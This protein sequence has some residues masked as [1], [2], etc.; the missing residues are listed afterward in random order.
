[1]KFPCLA[2]LLLLAAAVPASGALRDVQSLDPDWK[3]IKAD[4]A[5]G[6]DPALD[7]SR[8]ET[9][10]VPHT[11]NDTD[12]FDD[13]S[14]SDHRG[15][16]NQWGGVT[17][18][19]KHFT[20]PADWRGRTVIVEFEA[21]RQVAQVYL[22]GKLLGKNATGF[23]PFG[24]DLTPYLK[25]GS[26][27]VLAVKCDNSFAT[28]KTEGVA[29]TL[30]NSG[31]G[32]LY[33]WNNPHW[34]P[35]HGGIY[36]NVWLHA[37]GPV[38]ITLPLGQLGTT[39]AYVYATDFSPDKARVG[40]EAE[41]RNMTGTAANVSLGAEVLDREG[42]VVLRMDANGQAAAGQLTTL[43][44]S[45]ELRN[46][47]GWEPTSPY[48]YTVRLTLSKDGAPVDQITESLGVRK[49]AWDVKTGLTFNGQPLKLRGWGQKPTNE[50]A[51]L[52]TAYPDWMHYYT[53]AMMQAAGGNFIR[54]GHCAAGPAQIRADD[55]YGQI[56][57]QP[58]VD[59]EHDIADPTIWAVRAAAFRDVLIYYR[60][61]P[62]ILIW[63]AGNQSVTDEH[64][65]EL[66][67]LKD[68]YDPYGGRAFAFRRANATVGK[69]MDISVGTEG[70]HEQ[71]Q[72]PVVEG[73]YDR[74]EAPR[75]AWDRLTPPY[76]NYH[77]KGS[78]DLTAEQFAVNEV[79]QWWTK[80]GRFPEHC[81]GANWLFSDSTS[82][83]RV[84]TEVTRTSGEVDAVRLPKEAYYACSAMFHDAPTAAIIGHWNYPPG[85]VKPVYVVS[86]QPRVELFVN[87]K[88]LGLGQ[89]SHHYLFTFPGVAWSPGE[90]RAVASGEDGKA[91]ATATKATAGPAASLK[92]T[93]ITGPGGLRADGAD[94]AFFDVEAIDAKGNRCP[95]NEAPVHFTTGG[96]AV[97]RGGYNSG[98]ILSTNQSDLHLEGGINRVAIRSTLRPGTISL[99]AE[100]PGLQAAAATVEARPIAIVGGLSAVPPAAPPAPEVR[101]E[102]LKD[103]LAAVSSQGEGPSHNGLLIKDFNYSGPTR[104][105][106]IASDPRKGKSAYAETEPKFTAVP[107]FLQTSEFLRLPSADKGYS[108]LDLIS[109]S[110]VDDGFVAI[111][112]DRRL[113]L[114]AWL[115]SAFTDTGKDLQIGPDSLEI[116][117]RP[118]KSNETL[119]LGGNADRVEPNSLMYVV[120]VQKGEAH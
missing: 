30:P 101:P 113:P 103:R 23:V 51:G 65:Q 5:G 6:E 16:M 34:H 53:V 25:E 96:P 47:K 44:T 68:T 75:R 12:T 39:G 83:G 31:E 32:K 82:G 76:E 73:E 98:A 106:S 35:A 60:N 58:G 9:V 78:Y 86:N 116:Y 105:V 8:W 63:E 118:V 1:M 42:K 38:H 28:D 95:T 11:Y 33:P 61:H 4:V 120:F 100:A 114:P 36:R 90:I 17:W 22:N 104:T 92:L 2:F 72:L 88:S 7:D 91:T 20:V 66:R 27:N 50:W 37:L 21:V 94:I 97:W 29:I 48:L 45:G 46:P 26:A 119:T 54:W 85:T 108:A 87:G 111:A 84:S 79:A 107:G 40:V 74:E 109:L 115:T 64:A 67:K 13:W 112:Y 15:E 10:S 56:T 59:G 102:P 52:G 69:Y 41:L 19:R 57:L 93:P 3:F 99:R 14:P 81:G 49:A 24:F 77:A 80:L 71:P 70:S 62:S 110:V 89:P 117:Q 18:Y 55:L 43:K